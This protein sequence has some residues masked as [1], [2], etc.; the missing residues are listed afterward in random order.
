MRCSARFIKIY[1]YNLVSLGCKSLFMRIKSPS[2]A[3]CPF[4]CLKE[5]ISDIHNFYVP[6]KKKSFWLLSPKALNVSN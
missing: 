6:T 2:Y 3:V 1:I 4:F 5:C